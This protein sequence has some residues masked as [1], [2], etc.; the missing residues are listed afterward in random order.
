[1]KTDYPQELIEKIAETCHEVNRSY[2]EV[3]NDFSQVAWADAPQNIKQSAVDG[4]VFKLMNPE[5]TSKDMH[6]NWC[7]F[8][9]QDGWVFGE[10]KDAE[11][12]THPCLVEYE[13]LPQFQRAKDA[14]FSTIVTQM[15]KGVLNEQNTDA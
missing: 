14:I 2:C 5:A 15:S 13:Q 8:K 10:E 9:K 3:M 12:K 1:M 6:D 4:V 11:K 7:L